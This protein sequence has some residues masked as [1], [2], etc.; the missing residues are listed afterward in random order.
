VRQALERLRQA[1]HT[2]E[3]GGAV[4]LRSGEFGD[5]K[6]RVVVRDNGQP[7]YLASDIAYHL[8]KLERGFPSLVNIWGADHHG[9][10]ARLAAAVQ[11]LSGR[12]EALKVQLVQFVSL[13]RG[14]E[15]LSMSTR[16]GEYVTLRALRAEVGTDAAR[17]F[18]VLRSH[19]QHLDFDLKLAA[20]RSN[21]N[22]VY[23]IQYAHA[24]VESVLRQ[25]SEK[26][27]RWDRDAGRE[28]MEQL[29]QPHET[30]LLSRLSRYPEI[31]EQA[32]QT[33]SPHTLAH[34]LRDLADD[35]HSYYNAHT[36]L[37]EDDGLRNARLNL[38][39]GAQQ[40]IRNGLQLL[41]V[42]AP[43]HM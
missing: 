40:V 43:E 1:G 33:L 27:W 21:D 7:T 9:Y 39:I 15:K 24:R 38:T 13:F 32:A 26:G 31:V 22:P 37:V 5:E 18:Y 30:A 14:S 16:A 34:Y 42:S 41:G 36:F 10:V 6:D 4:W 20:S 12:Q 17:F 29:D 35:F 28:H 8:N 23:Y 11:A 25:L 3:S 2:Y 19:D